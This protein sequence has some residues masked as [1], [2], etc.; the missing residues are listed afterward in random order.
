MVT[1]DLAKRCHRQKGCDHRN[2]VDVH[3][4]DDFGWA[5]VKIGSDCWEGDVCDRRI[6]RGHS[7]GG[8]NCSGG[9]STG[10]LPVGPLTATGP[11][12][13]IIYHVDILKSSPT[14]GDVVGIRA[15]QQATLA[16]RICELCR[17]AERTRNR[18]ACQERLHFVPG[19][20][21]YSG[22][23]VKHSMTVRSLGEALI[24]VRTVVASHQPIAI[25]DFSVDLMEASSLAT[26]GRSVAAT[27]TSKVQD[28]KLRI[29]EVAGEIPL[30][31]QV[32]STHSR[33]RASDLWRQCVDVSGIPNLFLERAGAR[34]R[35]RQ[36]AGKTEQ[37]RQGDKAGNYRHRRSHPPAS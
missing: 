26:D 30:R 16:C 3:Y 7:E 4:P 11:S 31:R 29:L 19:G 24:V 1:D 25:A 17:M 13:E 34:K 22:L 10:V 32:R 35:W 20:Q 23:P 27:E 15:R 12:A 5:G 37:N 2:L 9:P 21:A 33:E 36:H 6:E 14:V 8:E 18:F 28:E